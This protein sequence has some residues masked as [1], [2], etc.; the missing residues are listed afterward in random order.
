MAEQNG[1][2]GRNNRHADINNQQDRREPRKQTDNQ[3][4]A[5]DYFDSSDERAHHV[6]RWNTNLGKTPRAEVAWIKKLLDSFYQKYS[7][8]ND[9]D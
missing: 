1:S 4:R 8:D 2:L 3:E 9:P 7:A 5:A 6:R